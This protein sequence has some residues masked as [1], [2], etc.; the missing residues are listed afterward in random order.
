[1]YDGRRDYRVPYLIKPP[2]ATLSADYTHPFNTILTHDLILAIL[3]GEVTNAQ[4][5]APWLD[6]HG[7][8]TPLIIGQGNE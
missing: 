5:V 4:N 3:R 1:L 8:Q 7:A 2:G 6:A